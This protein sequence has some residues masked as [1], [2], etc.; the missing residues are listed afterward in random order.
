MCS[1][2][3]FTVIGA[4]LNPTGALSI[5]QP[6]VRGE[7]WPTDQIIEQIDSRHMEVID[8]WGEMLR[9]N[10]YVRRSWLGDDMLHRGTWS[11]PVIV[12]ATAPGTCYPDGHPRPIPTACWRGTTGSAT[13]AAW[14]PMA[15]L[16]AQHALWICRPV[17]DT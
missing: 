17:R 12:L 2:S 4:V 10:R 14:P 9:S 8:R 11:E 13:C 6:P 7:H 5:R 16:Q 1:P 15:P 3:G